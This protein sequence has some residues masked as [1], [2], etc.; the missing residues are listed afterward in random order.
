M[1]GGVGLRSY[2]IL[3]VINDT[4]RNGINGC[5]DTGADQIIAQSE[6]AHLSFELPSEVRPK[7]PSTKELDISQVEK[8][9]KGE[10]APFYPAVRIHSYIMSALGV[11]PKSR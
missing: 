7:M 5:I 9:E 4:D 6:G 11:G 3:H 10:E 2:L 8:L 1:D